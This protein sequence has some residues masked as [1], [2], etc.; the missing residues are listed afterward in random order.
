MLLDLGWCG[1]R[2]AGAGENDSRKDGS[3]RS[4][5]RSILRDELHLKRFITSEIIT[6]KLISIRKEEQ[7]ILHITL[8]VRLI[9]KRKKVGDKF[10][11]K[12][13]DKLS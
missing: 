7:C 3:S 5:N 6:D 8:I 11:N 13:G 12:M 1:G 4:R 10:G 9:W 2:G